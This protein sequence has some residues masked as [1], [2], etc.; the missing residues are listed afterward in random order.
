MIENRMKLEGLP[1]S[2]KIFSVEEMP[3]KK[4]RTGILEIILCLKGSVQFSY[5]YEQ[6]TLKAGEYI[7]VDTDA[8]FFRNGRDNLCASFLIDL[9][10]YQDKYPYIKNEFF[11]CEGVS[12]TDVDYYPSAAH[13]TLRGLMFLILKS[14][15]ENDYSRIREMTDKIVDIFVRNFDLAVY[16]YGS[17]NIP[18]DTLVRMQ[19][20]N[21]Y[22]LNH[23]HEKITLQ[24]VAEG[25]NITTGYL[26]EFMRKNSIGFNNMLGYVRANHSETLL[27]NTNKNIVEISEECGFSDVKYYYS[28]FKKWYKCTPR[29]FKNRYS[30]VE[31]IVIEYKS[32]DEISAYLNELIRKHYAKIIM[33]EFQN[34]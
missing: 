12:E 16:H 1:L 10:E 30:Q 26:S 23:F 34:S 21:S 3:V 9:L 17:Q 31:D 11:V 25:L 20:I 8:Y 27:L 29:Q 15:S 24:D 7:A 6:F 19:Q 18:H 5:A 2:L 14:V 32:T 4:N 28:A 13:E 22:F 33:E